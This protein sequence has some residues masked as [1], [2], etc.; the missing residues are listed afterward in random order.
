MAERDL[1]GFDGHGAGFDLGQVEDVADEVEQIGAGGVNRLGE[2]D[3]LGRQI[4][5]GVLAHLLAEDEDAVERRAQLVR[6][7]GQELGLVLGSQS[8]LRGLFLQGVAG[9]LDFLVLPF[10]LGVLLGELLG[11]LGQLLVGLLQFVLLRLQLGGQLL[12]LLQQALGAHRG[13]DGVE[14]DADAFGQLREERQVGLREVGQGGQLDHGLDLAFEEH[15]QDDDC[16]AAQSRPGRSRCGCNPWGFRSSRMR[17]FSTAHWPTRPSPTLKFA[18]QVIFLR[19]RRMP[20]SI[21]QP[22]FAVVV[23][24]SLIHHAVLG[25]DQRRQLG[26]QLLADRDQIALALHHAG[27]L[28][29]VGLQPVLLGVL[30]GGGRG[31]CGSWR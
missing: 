2:L 29:E 18:G 7:V 15:R 22:G 28:G 12:R 16:C 10:H 5:V 30:L 6:H 9:L 1:L 8:Q 26:K 24:H 11:F 13:F 14:H 3:L 25:I 17:R 23:S 21:L 19:N 20:A 4:A 27:E 31:G